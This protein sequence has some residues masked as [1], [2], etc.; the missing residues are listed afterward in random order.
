[1]PLRESGPVSE[2]L[3]QA[4]FRANEPTARGQGSPTRRH[5]MEKTQQN[6]KKNTKKQLVAVKT[7]NEKQYWTRIGVAYEN[8]DGSWNL[9]IDYLPADLN[10]TTV[11]LR[12]F[13][14]R[15]GADDESGPE[16]GI[17]ANPF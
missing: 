17:V 16:H 12:D 15:D 8:Q 11:Q 10:G 14:R 6:S 4:G 1:M 13:Q 2:E 7:R 9:R 5:A 3:G